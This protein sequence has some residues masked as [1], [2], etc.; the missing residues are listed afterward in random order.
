MAYTVLSLCVEG[1]PAPTS[2]EWHRILNREKTG[3]IY[4]V[5][6]LLIFYW[7]KI[8]WLQYFNKKWSNHG[9]V[10]SWLWR[11]HSARKNALFKHVIWY[12]CLLHKQ[13]LQGNSSVGAKPLKMYGLIAHNNRLVN[14]YMSKIFK[15]LE[16]ESI[17]QE[18]N[19]FK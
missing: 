18:R 14:P 16:P 5:L 13:R 4:C 15:Y 19:P 7:R 12:D 1:S 9:Y 11:Q 6:I 17:W 8:N 10:F 2:V 3:W